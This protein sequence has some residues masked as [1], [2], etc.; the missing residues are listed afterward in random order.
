MELLILK[1][2]SGHTY[3]SA[4]SQSRLQFVA[5]KE[6]AQ[7]KKIETAIL[8]E[9]KPALPAL[10]AYKNHLA[11]D[12]QTRELISAKSMVAILQA[13]I[14][15]ALA[16]LLAGA[17]FFLFPP[18]LSS[19]LTTPLWI[20]LTA[21]SLILGAWKWCEYLS[22]SFEKNLWFSKWNLL[23]SSWASGLQSGQTFHSTCLEGSESWGQL[24]SPLRKHLDGYRS[25][26]KH[27]SSKKIQNN[28]RDPFIDLACE[29]CQLIFLQMERGV[30]VLEFLLSLIDDNKQKFQ[31]FIVKKG[32]LLQFQLMIPLMLCFL[33]A[34][35]LLLF[36]PLVVWLLHV[37]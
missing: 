21:C 4:K 1:I 31:Q 6:R 9:Q 17:S 3:L 30:P 5:P 20:P 29:Q 15:V 2:R 23:L 22:S 27:P 10:E 28:S 34:F 19:S 26:T 12:Y 8:D 32:D 25:N 37:Q 7:F 11:L 13:K 35:W 36:G 33:P 16:A 24:P 18:Q 14:L